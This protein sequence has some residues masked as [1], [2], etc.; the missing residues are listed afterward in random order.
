MLLLTTGLD[1]PSTIPPQPPLHDVIDS[2]I[3]LCF[4]RG[5]GIGDQTGFGGARENFLYNP[6]EAGV[7][8]TG[9]FSQLGLGQAQAGALL[10]SA[11]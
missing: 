8:E 10:A 4:C 1:L 5:C 11:A 9:K 3:Q 6:P 7:Q 2:G